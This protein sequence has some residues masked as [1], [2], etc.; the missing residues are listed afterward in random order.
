MTR[1][2]HRDNTTETSDPR[3]PPPGIHININEIFRD[4][5]IEGTYPIDTWLHLF[6]HLRYKRQQRLWLQPRGCIIITASLLFPFVWFYLATRHIVPAVFASFMFILLINWIFDDATSKYRDVKIARIIDKILLPMLHI[7]QADTRAKEPLRLQ[8]D[9][10]GWDLPDKKV[11]EINHGDDKKTIDTCYVDRWLEGETRL[12][13]RS[14]LTWRFSHR[15]RARRTTFRRQSGYVKTKTR[16]KYATHVEIQLRVPHRYYPGVLADP[17]PIAA[18][19]LTLRRKQ[20][21]TDIRIKQTYMQD[22]SDLDIRPFVEAISAAYQQ[23]ALPEPG[24]S[25][26]VNN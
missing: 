15:V 25:S 22:L 10:R 26:S 18:G 13:D 1:L 14:R 4:K 5:R 12:V 7:L 9:L 2:T 23:V 3:M 20:D 17:T 16:H 24:A 21:R 6:Q 19:K 11:N 8:I